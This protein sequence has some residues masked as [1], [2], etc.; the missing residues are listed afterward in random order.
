M[1]LLQMIEEIEGL[2]DSQL[3][4]VQKIGSLEK[5]LVRCF[6]YALF[7]FFLVVYD[8]HPLVL[9]SKVFKGLFCQHLKNLVLFFNSLL[10]P[11][12]HTQDE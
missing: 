12:S 5:E 8:L 9:S 11:S 7:Y 3:K 6:A 4:Q 1:T 10:L 2:K